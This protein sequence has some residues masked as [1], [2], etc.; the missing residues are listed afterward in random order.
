MKNF[1][2]LVFLLLS[3]SSSYA[4]L[5]INEVMPVNINYF[6]EENN[7]PD[8]WIELRN[9][10]DERVSLKNYSIQRDTE[11]DVYHIAVDTFV[12]PNSFIVLNC[13]GIGRDLHAN[14]KLKYKNSATIRFISP[15]GEI[16]DVLR[17]PTNKQV[18]VSYGCG[19]DDELGWLIEPTP[20][21]EN[22]NTS[23]RFL[24]APQLTVESG[25]Y[26][27]PF[28]V[29]LK[30]T[31]SDET[32]R[33]T[34]DGTTPTE[35]DSVFPPMGLEISRTTNLRIK[36]FANGCASSLNVVYSYLFH[37]REITLPVIALSVDYQD[38][39]GYREGILCEKQYWKYANYFYDWIREADIK[40]FDENGRM[41]IN[42]K[43]HI[44]V[45]G[46]TSRQHPMKSFALYS[47]ARY[48]A[49]NFEY[50]FFKEKSHVE[51]YNS[52]SLRNAGND[53][54]LAHLRDAVS[55]TYI[56]SVMKDV[57]Y[58][59]YQPVIVYLNGEYYGL[60]NLRE[61][62]NHS[63]IDANHPECVD[64]ID[65]VEN[66]TTSNSG[67]MKNAMTFY[68]HFM[69]DTTTYETLAQEM[70]IPEFLNYY[71]GELY[72]GNADFPDNNVVMWRSRKEGGRWR[73]ILKDLDMTLNY[74]FE[75]SYPYMF[76]ISNFFEQHLLPP[77][78]DSDSV[79][80]YEFSTRLIRRLC[81][82]RPFQRLLIENL[83]VDLGDIFLPEYVVAHIDS[84]ARQ[85]E[86]EF[87]FTYDLYHEYRDSLNVDWYQEVQFMKDYLVGRNRML[88]NSMGNFFKLGTVYALTVNKE[89]QYDISLNINE[90]E[91]VHSVFDGY[92]YADRPLM[93]KAKM[94]DDSSSIAGWKI[95]MVGRDTM[96]YLVKGDS[97]RFLLF[98][99]N[100]YELVKIN[101]I[102]GFDVPEIAEMQVYNVD[103]GL[104]VVVQ[105]GAKDFSVYD[106]LGRDYLHRQLPENSMIFLR[107]PKGCYILHSG[108][109]R[110]KVI[111][112]R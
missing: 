5:R 112:D 43:G 41:E 47:S 42:Q 84:L 66:W 33:Y 6:D 78:E 93:I 97:L 95:D 88:Y 26:D 4:E 31:K 72:F 56:A 48:G 63:N 29:N 13:D 94:K 9:C 45:M 35:E 73:W 24:T 1:G 22:G 67:D 69:S 19:V 25:L 50:P 3:L 30:E 10:S 109:E 8:S 90:V 58:Q 65:V 54:L 107:L 34:M 86:Y 91:M 87:P 37:E 52:V 74:R 96:S 60:M 23:K 12:A 57:D 28:V 32:V 44:R 21:S 64:N 36:S 53:F 85:I 81:K 39:Y 59:A 40:Y 7:L 68:Q 104:I 70:D 89:R 92:Y 11:D 46:N 77:A 71:I 102:V 2:C 38:L 55:Q 18:G 75:Y 14:F 51:K 76:F 62:S 79:G 101:P 20:M 106:L 100:I 98:D 110:R 105:K 61:R 27:V 49:E 15:L 16:V 99:E 82:M 80:S 108:A 17:V 83:S 103:G 111:V